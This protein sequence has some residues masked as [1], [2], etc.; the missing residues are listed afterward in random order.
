MQVENQLPISTPHIYGFLRT[1]A[2]SRVPPSHRHHQTQSQSTIGDVHV[3]SCSNGAD[4][5]TTTATTGAASVQPIDSHPPVVGETAVDS[6]EKLPVP[7][8]ST[9][10]SLVSATKAKGKKKRRFCEDRQLLEHMFVCDVFRPIRDLDE[11]TF[12]DNVDTTIEACTMMAEKDSD[13]V[14]E[15]HIKI[16]A[17]ADAD[18]DADIVSFVRSSRRRL[19][20][21]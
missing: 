7:S 8:T 14:N 18:A 21:T 4:A 5:P 13:T 9:A 6:T 15:N 11:P 10:T 1:K 3:S 12:K 17:E 20:L 2:K 16:V 19:H